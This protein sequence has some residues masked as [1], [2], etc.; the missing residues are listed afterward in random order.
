VNLV[1]VHVAERSPEM[2]VIVDMNAPSQNA[3]DAGVMA[4][5]SAELEMVTSP[6]LADLVRSGKIKLVTYR[7]LVDRSGPMS[8]KPSP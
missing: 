4:H 7:T 8:S 6:E 5:R 1:E 2:A 3:P